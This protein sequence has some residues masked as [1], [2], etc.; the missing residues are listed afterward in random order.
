M[1][2]Q[3]AGRTKGGLM[4]GSLT[5]RPVFRSLCTVYCYAV[6][7]LPHPHPPVALGLLKVKPEPCM[8]VT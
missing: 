5:D 4:R 6:K 1:S 8:E 2:E 7:L 3:V